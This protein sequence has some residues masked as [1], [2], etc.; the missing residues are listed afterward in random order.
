M[1]PN[2]RIPTGISATSALKANVSPA[3]A[4]NI[5]P[6]A[7]NWV[8]KVETIRNARI[9]AGKAAVKDAKARLVLVKAALVLY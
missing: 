6:I 1:G 3:S 5:P 7:S 8:R 4:D 9:P 2:T